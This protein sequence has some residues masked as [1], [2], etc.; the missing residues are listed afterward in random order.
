MTS[1]Q[2][3]ERGRVP[4]ARTDV[5]QSERRQRIGEGQRELLVRLRESE[6]HPHRAAELRAQQPPGNASEAQPAPPPARRRLSQPGWRSVG[7]QESE[8]PEAAKNQRS[9]AK[10]SE[11]QQNPALQHHTLAAVGATTGGGDSRATIPS[12]SAGPGPHK[13]EECGRESERNAVGGPFGPTL[14]EGEGCGGGAGLSEGHQ[15]RV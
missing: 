6:N 2:K 11:T 15:G 4:V 10:P 3:R 8:S 7:R 5:W 9:P 1:H 13:L 12:L 14:V